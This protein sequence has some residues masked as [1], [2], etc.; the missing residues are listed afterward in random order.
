M[1]LDEPRERARGDRADLVRRD[2]AGAP[3]ARRRASR[4]LEACSCRRSSSPSSDALLATRLTRA[5]DEPR[6]LGGPPAPS[7]KARR[8]GAPQY[9]TDRARFLGRGR[10]IRTPMSMIDGRPLSN[11]TGA[12]L[13]P[14]FSLR[15]R[16]RLAAGRDARAS[17]SR[18]WSRRSRGAALDLADKYRDPT[19]FERAR[20]AGLDAG[21]GP[22]PPSRHRA[23]RG[24]PL[25]ATSPTAIL[26]SD[27]TP[28][29]VARD[30]GAQRAAA[31]RRSGHTASPATCPIVLVRIDEVEDL[32]IVRQLL[33]AHEY[34]RMKR[35]AVDL[36]ILERAAAVVPQDL[37]GALEALVRASQARAR[38]R[39]R[40]D[41]RR[42]RPARPIASRRR[43]ATCLQTAARAV[44]AQSP[45]ARSPSRSRATTG[46]PADRV[47]PAR[48]AEALPPRAP[49]TRPR[50]RRRD[51]S[52]E[53]CNGLGG[54]ADGRARS[55]STVLGEGQWTPAPWINVIA[56]AALRLPGLES[57]AGYAWVEQ[58]PR[59]PAHALVERSGQR[60][61]GES[62]LRPRRG[63]RRALG[64]DRRCPSARTAC[65]LRAPS[66]PG[67]QSLRAHRARDRARAHCSSFRSTTR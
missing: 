41:G 20:D 60:P 6:G 44:L 55:T 14:I 50:R 15:R 48:A 19:T 16:V 27:P 49:I 38:H 54:F 4:V 5:P 37:Q 43:S 39:D 24:A 2:R 9:E 32:G 26:Y 45:A 46:A 61:A 22:A 40:H 8:V 12:V 53:F 7:W 34:W 52:S 33:R 23:R 42:V 65:A 66:R 30:A 51:R 64:P 3:A 28:A 57:G 13:D 11:T 56:N 47:P 21:A 1:S 10:G 63:D 58:Q 35:L 29:A 25:P 67:L 17:R 18:R 36:V 31:I 59:E 62:A